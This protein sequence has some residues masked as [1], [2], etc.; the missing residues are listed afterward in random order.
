M[1]CRSM[2]FAQMCQIGSSTTK[3]GIWPLK[4]ANPFTP[5]PN[6]KTSP[7]FLSWSSCPT[8]I[9]KIESLVANWNRAHARDGC[10]TRRWLGFRHSSIDGENGGTEVAHG[11]A[12]ARHGGETARPA[13]S[14]YEADLGGGLGFGLGRRAVIVKHSCARWNSAQGA[15][16]MRTR[17]GRAA[18]EQL[19]RA[20]T[21]AW[22]PLGDA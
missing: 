19:S 18:A 7:V 10:G 4:L 13:I 20:A 17:P 1:H 15:T 21:L 5:D 11:G 16:V 14:G 6:A 3:P 2:K 22:P 12:P 8:S 9:L